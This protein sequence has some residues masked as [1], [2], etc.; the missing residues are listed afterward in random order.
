MTRPEPTTATSAP[1][2][3]PGVAQLSAGA[4]R[5]CRSC[6]RSALV[7]VVDLGEQPPAERF[8]AE[9]D[10]ATPEPR[11]PLRILVCQRCWLVQLD[12]DPVP[13]EDEPGGIAFASSTMARHVRE[14]AADSL[15]RVAARQPRVIEI[16]SHGNRL[17]ELFGDLGA[18]TTLIEA[19]PAYANAAREA[20]V[21]VVGTRLTT[22]TADA[23]AANGL[24]D[25]FVDAFYLAHDPRPTEYLGGVKRLLAPGGVAVFEFDHVLPVIEDRQYDGFRHGHASYLSLAAFSRMLESVDL[26]PFDAARTPA[27]GGSLRVFVGHASPRRPTDTVGEIRSAEAAAGL[28]RLD[29]YEAF[30]Q[31]VDAGRLRLRRFLD[32]RRAE[33]RTVVGYGA[34]SRGNTLL[35]SSNVGTGD[36]AFVVDRSASKQGRYLPGSRIPIREPGAIDDARPDYLLILTWDISTEVMRQMSHVREWGCRFVVPVPDMAIVD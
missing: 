15:R 12:G 34:P 35:N 10:L 32:A 19:A 30:A 1:T 6:G 7:T 23:V 22:E 8:L 3:D 9:S 28:A 33:G 11:L 4:T 27:Y 5:V 25:L 36:L 14:L 24:A 17:H 31:D 20:G 18:T 16:A 13:S 29:T 21:P 2:Q 26:V